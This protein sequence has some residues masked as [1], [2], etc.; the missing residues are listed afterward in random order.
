MIFLIIGDEEM[1]R[2]LGLTLA[3]FLTI[4]LTGCSSKKNV[5]EET[6][7][8]NQAVILENQTVNELTFENFN[9]A[10]DSDNITHIYFEITN[11]TENNISV[12]KVTITLYSNDE[13]VLSLPIL[14]SKT[15]EYNDTLTIQKQLDVELSNV[16][17]VEYT[18]E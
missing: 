10:T 13:Q 12:N 9:I 11:N 5:E 15:F 8:E 2:L 16:D 3:I 18:V 6:T 17:R 1:K 7:E 14:V 4:T